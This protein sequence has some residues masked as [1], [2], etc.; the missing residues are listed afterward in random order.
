MKLSLGMNRS[1]IRVILN[2]KKGA[3]ESKFELKYISR[4]ELNS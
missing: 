1:R 3:K 4:R 2:V